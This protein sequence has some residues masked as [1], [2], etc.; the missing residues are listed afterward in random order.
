MAI[1]MKGLKLKPNYGDLINV[2]VSDKSYNVK[3]RNRSA[4]FF[5]NGFVLSQLDGEG[6]IIMERQHEQ[7]N[8]HINSTY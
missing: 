8:N 4:Q 7:A 6:A 3:F 5:R 1:S 2:V